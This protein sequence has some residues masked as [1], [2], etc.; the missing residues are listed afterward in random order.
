MQQVA[1][2][3]T[4]QLAESKALA[5]KYKKELTD[6]DKDKYKEDIKS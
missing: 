2:D 4:K 5:E 1:A 3:A 6:L